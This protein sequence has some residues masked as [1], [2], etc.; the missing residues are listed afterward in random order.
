MFHLSDI[1]TV[2][3]L[4]VLHDVRFSL[5]ALSNVLRLVNYS[6]ML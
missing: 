3:I 6:F 2:H 4:H 5:E 1:I